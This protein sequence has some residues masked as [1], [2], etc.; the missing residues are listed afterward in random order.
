MSA[1]RT[2]TLNKANRIISALTGMADNTNLGLIFVFKQFFPTLLEESAKYALFPFAAVAAIFQALLGWNQVHINSGKDSGQILRAIIGT[3]TAISITAAVVISLAFGKTPVMG[4][5]LG[6][7]V[8]FIFAA[9]ILA[10]TVIHLAN[11]AYYGA[12]AM[13]TKPTVTAEESLSGKTEYPKELSQHR[14]A[15][16]NNLLAAGVGAEI[17]ATIIAVM[18]YEQ[19]QVSAILGGA[20]ALTGNALMLYLLSQQIECGNKKQDDVFGDDL[21]A[22]RTL[23]ARDEST[24]CCLPLLSL[25][26]SNRAPRGYLPVAAVE[27]ANAA[28]GLS[29]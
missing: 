11:S 22:A 21:E 3:L 6:E 13:L 18:I 10:N 12:R 4:Y 16:L 19:T 14:Q 8:P 25:F 17:A 7:V 24:T 5:E 9:T 28:S 29:I 1:S 2:K 15:V 27:P 26:N 20:T 23:P